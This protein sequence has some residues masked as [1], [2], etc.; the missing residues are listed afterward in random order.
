M[1][2]KDDSKTLDLAIKSILEQTYRNF[3]LLIMDDGSKDNTN[4]IL[5]KYS[6]KDN[7][8]KIHKND[9]NLGL[10]KSLN[11]LITLSNGEYIA[12]Q[13]ADDYSTSERLQIQLEY[14]KRTDVDAVTSR[15][16]IISNEKKIPGLSFF[17]PLKISS[18]YKNPFIHGTL[19]IKK[20]VIN[21]IGNYNEN[22]LYAQDYKL[23]ID[24]LYSDYR[25]KN[26][27]E[28]LYYLNME[29]NI[30]ANYSRE[31]KYYFECARKNIIP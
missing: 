8:V 1:S 2:T 6:K 11:Q 17:I 10:T 24:L 30:S 28:I 13:D 12:R 15:A 29:D 25:I 5:Q 14:I 18:K 4:N 16:R 22:F 3:E 27:N 20:K 31:Q 26:L 19:L 9:S 7:R 21:E 23:F